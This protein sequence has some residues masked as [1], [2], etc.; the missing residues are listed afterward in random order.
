[1]IRMHRTLALVVVALWGFWLAAPAHA[2][3]T[4]TASMGNWTFTV[5]SAGGTDV[6][7]HLTYNCNTSTGLSWRPN[8]TVRMCLSIGAGSV[9]G[10]TIGNRLLRSASGE[11]LQFQIYQDAAR[12]QVL[13]NSAANPTY[14]QALVE[15]PLQSAFFG[16]GATGST[17]G[18]IPLYG[19][20]LPQ[21]DIAPGSYSSS[22]ANTTLR[23]R[24]RELA[25]TGSD[26]T[27]CESGGEQGAPST[28]SFTATATVPASC[29]INFAGAMDFGSIYATE[30]GQIDRNSAIS[31]TCTRGTAWR[32][33]LNNGVNASGDQRRMSGPNGQFI[34][35]DLYRN[36]ERWSRWGNTLNVDTAAGTGTGQAQQVNVYGRLEN[37]WLSQAGSYADTITVTVTY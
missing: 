15:Y 17:T 23:Y 29:S 1:M 36:P 35:Y 13:G 16:L 11:T 6:Q 32:M 31:L 28:L 7:S 25:L 18:T 33:G 3:T 8:A 37:Q 10:S 27:T 20:I 14:F 21:A 30:T 9:P 34:A 26:P 4:C 12:T 19:R 24:Y 2:T 5:N 22:F